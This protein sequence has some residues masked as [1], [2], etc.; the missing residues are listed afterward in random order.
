MTPGFLFATAAAIFAIIGVFRRDIRF[1]AIAVFLVFI[2]VT[3]NLTD[4]W[5]TQPLW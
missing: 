4:P 3:S 5:W 2:N 1:S